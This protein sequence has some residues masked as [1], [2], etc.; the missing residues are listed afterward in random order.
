MGNSSRA[1][2]AAD[3]VLRLVLVGVQF[4][5]GEDDDADEGQKQD[6]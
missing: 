6:S 2:L 4:E 5:E 3:A 1:E